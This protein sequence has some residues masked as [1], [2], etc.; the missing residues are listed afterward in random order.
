MNEDSLPLSENRKLAFRIIG[1]LML[2]FS[3]MYGVYATLANLFCGNG[4]FCSNYTA[5]TVEL[6]FCF[7]FIA[8]ASVFLGFGFI[9]D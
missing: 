7:V 6:T 8:I 9:R 2:G 3:I 5:P 4:N 1:F